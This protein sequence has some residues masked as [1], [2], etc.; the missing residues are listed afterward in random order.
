MK[1]IKIAIIGL[2][3]V[4]LPLARLFAS[5]FPVVGYDINKDRVEELKTGIDSTLEVDPELL[6]SVLVDYNP[7]V[8]KGH[9]AWSTEHGAQGNQLSVIGYRLSV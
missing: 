5:K 6:R 7:T 4:G 9:G 1:D 3:Y 8:K 2:G